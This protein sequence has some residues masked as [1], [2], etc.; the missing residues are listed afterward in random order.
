MIKSGDQKPNMSEFMGYAGI[1]FPDMLREA[2]DMLDPDVKQ[3]PV[4]ADI[5]DRHMIWE[6][7]RK[8]LGKDVPNTPQ[9][10]G[11]CVGKSSADATNFLQVLQLGAVGRKDWRE[12]HPSFA[13]ANG[14]VM[15]EIGNR[16][17]GRQDG[18][19][20]IWQAVAV[21]KYGII[22]QDD[23]NAPKYT[24][25]LARNW[26]YNG[27]P[28]EFLEI[29][30]KRLVRVDTADTAMVKT[31]DQLFSALSAGYPVTVA[32]NLGFD[33]SPRAD[34]YNH[35]SDTWPHQ[36]TFTGYCK[37]GKRPCVCLNNNWG[38][39]VHGLVKDAETG[40]QWPKGTL[41]ISLNDAQKML[42][43]K[44]SWA[45]SFVE[46][47]IEDGKPLTRSDFDML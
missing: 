46:I 35:N 4:Y 36:M 43:E 30:K 32:S 14:R 47:G 17:L 34:G 16:R 38:E 33:M 41:C 19:L 5:P 40:D 9:L 39:S 21:K 11:D 27:C 2:F 1:E 29:G 42:N 25:A 8:Y 28:K 12:T 23:K 22:F 18:S 44:D 15:P 24:A 31:L 3:M 45:H 7:I 6:D 26:G 37:I 10:I 13:W 20:G